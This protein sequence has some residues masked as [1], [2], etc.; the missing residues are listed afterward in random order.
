[1]DKFIHNPASWVAIAFLI[2]AYFTVRKLFP[3]LGSSLDSYSAKIS[4]EIEE[5]KVL[6][7]EAEQLLLTAQKKSAEAER[8]A[9]EIVERAKFDAKLIAD[10]A[11]KDIEREID[12]KMKIAEEKIKNAESAAV[13]HVRNRAVEIAVNAATEILTK[14][15]QAEKTSEKLVEKSIRLISSNLS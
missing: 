5:A 13:E 12:R 4:K 11:E 1:M 8:T 10:E 6:K 7:A 3:K 2:F 9:S 14:E 15:L